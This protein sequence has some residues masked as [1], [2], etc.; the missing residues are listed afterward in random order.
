MDLRELYNAVALLLDD[1]EGDLGDSH[2]IHLRLQQTLASMRA[3]GMP[4]PNDLVQMEKELGAEF[5]A[6]AKKNRP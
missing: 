2:E 6:D 3:M 5:E 4:L 1:I